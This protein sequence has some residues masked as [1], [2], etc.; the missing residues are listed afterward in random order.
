MKVLFKHLI[1]GYT[2]KMDDAVIYYNK[3][4]NKVII[5]KIGKLTLGAHHARF[6]AISQN[7]YSL[8]PSQGYKD[9]LYRYAL[10]LR[11]QKAHRYD[12]ILVWNNLYSKIMYAMAK[13]Y[14]E[15][16]DLATLTRAQIETDNL[17]CRCVRL[18]V[19]A[20]LLPWV[21]GYE[22]LTNLI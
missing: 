13:A 15:T 2:G 18:A 22:A 21:K 1:A 3:Y 4:L 8:H 5:R 9:D 16:V 12:G 6:K 7:I 10:A 14:P 20:D 11:K 19:D 17:P